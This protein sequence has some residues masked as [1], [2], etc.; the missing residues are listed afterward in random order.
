MVIGVAAFMGKNGV[1]CWFEQ[2]VGEGRRK[3]FGILVDALG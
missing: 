2:W 1:W 3:M